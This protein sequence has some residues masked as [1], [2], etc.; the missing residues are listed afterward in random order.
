MSA[1]SHSNSSER[2]SNDN[3]HILLGDEDAD[4]G[5][6]LYEGILLGGEEP[7]DERGKSLSQ[8]IYESLGYSKKVLFVLCLGLKG[9]GNCPLIDI[10]WSP[11]SKENKQNVKPSNADLAVE[12]QCRQKVLEFPGSTSGK[13][14]ASY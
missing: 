1:S 14:F 10:D 9:N 6:D 7:E 5:G 3:E 8:K 12:V 13:Y 2:E 11:W 4:D